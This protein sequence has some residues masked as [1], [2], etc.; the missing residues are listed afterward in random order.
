VDPA[1][2]RR[3]AADGGRRPGLRPGAA[4]P[5]QDPALR[6]DR[7][8]L[9]DDGQRQGPQGRHA[10]DRHR[11]AGPGRRRGRS[12]RLSTDLPPTPI[13]YHPKEDLTNTR[14]GRTPYPPPTWAARRPFG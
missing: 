1:A 14:T 8:G 11:D 7:R 13:S 3:A 4:R 5:L 10:E 9:P 2:S 6:A 12:A